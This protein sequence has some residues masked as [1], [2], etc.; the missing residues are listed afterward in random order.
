MNRSDWLTDE[1]IQAVFERRAARAVPGDLRET[2]VTL[3]AASSQRSPWRLYLE[4]TYQ[5]FKLVGQLRQ[6]GRVVLNSFFSPVNLAYG[7]V[8]PGNF[9]GDF[10]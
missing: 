5:G 4:M 8:D 7:H 6:S 3:S 1:L 2:I 9:P 10:F